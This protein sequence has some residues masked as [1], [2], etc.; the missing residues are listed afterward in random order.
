MLR[1]SKTDG[2][3]R[4]RSGPARVLVVDDDPDVCELVARLLEQATYTVERCAEHNQAVQMLK[5]ADPPYSAVVI[6]FQSGGTSS[7]LKL[8]DAVRHLD[9]AAKARTPTIILTST[10]TNRVFAWQ[11][12]SDGFL[13][14]PFHAAELV[15]GVHTM[16]ERTDEERDQFRREMMRQARTAQARRIAE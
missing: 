6:D 11:S 7:S 14:R 1:R 15:E 2:D 3:E 10:D 8:L 5:K 12:G 16:L 9:E 4:H 13:V